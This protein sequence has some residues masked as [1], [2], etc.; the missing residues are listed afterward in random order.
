[1]GVENEGDRTNLHGD[2]HLNLANAAERD[3]FGAVV[4]ADPAGLLRSVIRSIAAFERTMGFAPFPSKLDQA[5]SG[6]VVLSELDQE[7]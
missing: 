3:E 6:E 2:A 1:M 5:I 7:G 4:F